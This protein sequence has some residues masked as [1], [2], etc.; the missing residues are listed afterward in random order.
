MGGS[1]APALWRN[2]LSIGCATRRAERVGSAVTAS[3]APA[4]VEPQRAARQ[5]DDLDHL[6]RHAVG[7]I[8]L[9]QQGRVARQRALALSNR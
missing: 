7:S 6:V 5:N 4:T 1:A 2:A 3:D 9:G 8:R